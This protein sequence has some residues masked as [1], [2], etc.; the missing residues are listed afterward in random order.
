LS[1]RSLFA[2]L[3][4]DG[5]LWQSLSFSA[6]AAAMST[7]FEGGLFA[8]TQICGA[9]RRAKRAGITC[10]VDM[11]MDD[12]YLTDACGAASPGALEQVEFERVAA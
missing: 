2:T 3:S 12:Q 9:R 6:D 1:V 11:D 7:F 8:F 10:N 4:R 5:A